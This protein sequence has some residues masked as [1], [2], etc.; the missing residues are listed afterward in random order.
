MRFEEDGVWLTPGEALHAQTVANYNAA[1]D[2][3][4]Q[5]RLG[6]IEWIDSQLPPDAISDRSYEQRYLDRWMQVRIKWQPSDGEVIRTTLSDSQLENLG[7]LMLESAEHNLY[8]ANHTEE[9][10]AEYERLAKE[11]LSDEEVA[12]LTDIDEEERKAQKHD[13]Q[14][15]ALVDYDQEVQIAEAIERHLSTKN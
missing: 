13:L 12:V 11:R 5:V 9:H 14:Q 4:T 15:M 8:I 2:I 10:M 1:D 6:C 3:W 7:Q